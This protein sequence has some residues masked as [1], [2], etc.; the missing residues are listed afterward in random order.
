MK[1]NNDISEY[2]NIMRG[3]RQGC[4]LSPDLFNIYSEMILRNPEDIEGVKVGGYNCNNLRYADDTVLIASSEKDLQKLIDVVSNGS[5]KM[6]LSLNVK[7]SE[8]MSISKNKS[9]PTCNVN[10]NGESIK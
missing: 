2:I 6:G 9:P 10:I 5:I 1:V 8:C 7:K 4:V 3:I